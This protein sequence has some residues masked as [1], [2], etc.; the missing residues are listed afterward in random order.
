MTATHD[1]AEDIRAYGGHLGHRIAPGAEA[2]AARV[3]ALWERLSPGPHCDGAMG[4]RHSAIM[5]RLPFG[6]G[7]RPVG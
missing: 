7:L 1:L 4:E 2:W 5:A 3:L 6:A